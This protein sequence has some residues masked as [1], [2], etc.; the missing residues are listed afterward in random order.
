MKLRAHVIAVLACTALLAAGCQRAASTAPATDALDS[1]LTVDGAQPRDPNMD[2]LAT[3]IALTSTAQAAGIPGQATLPAT[4]DPNAGLPTLPPATLDPAAGLLPTL[5]PVPP[6][7]VPGAACASPYIVKTGDWALRIAQQC[8]VSLDALAAANPGV[9]LDR[10]AVGQQLAVPAP[11]TNAPAG[12]A[13]QV[14]PPPASGQP[15]TGQ[16][17]VRTGDNLF[18]LAYNCNLT[19]EQLAALNNIPWPYQIK[20]GQIIRFP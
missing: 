9:N 16:Y 13:T 6:T 2:A 20:V 4:T 5:T 8:G 17:T 7:A 12:A 19:T 10:L 14:A 1:G 3:Q 11:G 15:C 18:R